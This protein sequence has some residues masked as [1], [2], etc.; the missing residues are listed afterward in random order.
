M[1]YGIDFFIPKQGESLTDA[2]LDSA[3]INEATLTPENKARNTCIIE[4]LQ[5]L[6][7]TLKIINEDTCQEI[8]DDEMGILISLYNTSG[9]MSIAYWHDS[10]AEQLYSRVSAYLSIIAT[11][12]DF[13]FF[14]PQTGEILNK[15]NNFS[16]SSKDYQRGAHVLNE[17][18]SQAS[19]SS[20]PKRT[21]L[22]RYI[23]WLP[24]L[25]LAAA[26]KYY[27][28]TAQHPETVRNN[29]K[30]QETT[31]IQQDF[32]SL[33]TIKAQ[34]D[35]T[36]ERSSRSNKTNMLTWVIK[37]ND[38]VMLERNAEN[39]TSYRYYRFQPNNTYTIHLKAFFNGSYHIVSNTVTIT[40]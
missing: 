10:N 6:T 11:H 13:A 16:I 21:L 38:K 14:D 30:P 31:E 19:P 35:L 8:G 15:E 20:K 24:F 18:A 26:L 7:P 28:F 22:Q 3:D 40:P 29:P 4:A 36:V 27:N 25:L 5:A 12:S 37:E 39:E 34:Q 33:Y 32:T 9:G 23:K 17:M 1:G 2:A